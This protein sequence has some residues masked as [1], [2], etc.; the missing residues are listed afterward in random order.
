MD[1][2]AQH[3]ARVRRVIMRVYIYMCV[4]RGRDVRPYPSALRLG[5]DAFKFLAYFLT[6]LLFVLSG[7]G[8]APF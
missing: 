4:C 1:A 2:H 7:W 3:F 5:A 6:H 8:R